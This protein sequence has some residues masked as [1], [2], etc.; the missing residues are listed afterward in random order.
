M[1]E[2]ILL[3]EKSCN[4]KGCWSAWGSWADC[5]IDTGIKARP[6]IILR[7]KIIGLSQ[8]I[9]PCSSEKTRSRSCSDGVCAEST[10]STAACCKIDSSCELISFVSLVSGIYFEGHWCDRELAAMII[11]SNGCGRWSSGGGTYEEARQV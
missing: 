1:N 4:I 7:D 2:E 9:R 11:H 8:T 10:S 5:N 6:P 3:D